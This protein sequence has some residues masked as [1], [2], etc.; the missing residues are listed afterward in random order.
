MVTWRC[1]RVVD[2]P[3]G[4]RINAGNNGCVDCGVGFWQDRRAQAACNE[5]P[6]N[7]LTG[8]TRATSEDDCQREYHHGYPA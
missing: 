8:T 3:P 4:T 2:C 6:D 5:C 7:L 1:S